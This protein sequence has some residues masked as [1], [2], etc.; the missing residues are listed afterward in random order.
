[1]QDA[2]GGPVRVVVIANC[3]ASRVNVTG[4]HL[5]AH[6]GPYEF[7]AN[8]IEQLSQNEDRIDLFGPIHPV[9]WSSNGAW[10]PFSAAVEDSDGMLPMIHG[11]FREFF[12]HD[13]PFCFAR[14]T[15]A[16]LELLDILLVGS[17]HE[18]GSFFPFL[19]SQDSRLVTFL[20][21]QLDILPSGERL[22]VRP[23]PFRSRG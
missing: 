23:N 11:R 9:P 21:S 2:S 4:W 8:G 7:G 5:D 22:I 3:V 12:Q 20:M 13:A 1:L 16:R 10:Y 17:A 19:V 18:M 6:R 14:F 15:A